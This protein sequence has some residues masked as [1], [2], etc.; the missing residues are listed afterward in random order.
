MISGSKF[1]SLFPLCAFVVNM[2]V[3]TPRIECDSSVYDFGT[4]TDQNKLTHEFVI[5]NRGNTP[6]TITKVRACCGMKASMDCM[7][8]APSTSSVCRA[9]F[10]LS[11]RSGDQNKKIY[12][13]SD[14][15]K[16]PYF[17]LSLTG[18]HIR[19]SGIPPKKGIT[20]NKT[21]IQAVPE[22]IIVL[23]GQKEELQRQ[24]M[25]TDR[26]GGSFD[27]LSAE[28]VNAD[29]TVEFSRLRPDRWKCSLSI[30]SASINPSAALKIT[31]SSKD[32]LEVNIPISVR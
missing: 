20:P 8:I 6:L 22:S 17:A 9:V 21:G 10:D 16:R 23:S 26:N 14:D 29:G 30:L 28:L 4:V 2:A 5:W 32:Q 11:R 27:I 19:P 3:A 12:L 1:L 25:L 7:E 18:T 24:V 31:I 13:A 15:P